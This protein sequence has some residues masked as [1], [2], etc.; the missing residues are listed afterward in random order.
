[1][2]TTAV[3]CA[4]LVRNLGAEFVHD[5]WNCYVTTLPFG[6]TLLLVWS[7]ACGWRWG[8]PLGMAAA[9]FVA[10]VHVG[11]VLL[12]LPAVAAG[13]V[14]LCVRSW[15]TRRRRGR[16]IRRGARPP[17][18]TGGAGPRHARCP[19]GPVGATGPGRARARPEQP[20][21][22]RG[23]VPSQRGRR[24]HAHPGPADHRWAVQPRRR[25]ARRQGS[26]VPGWRV[27]I[28]LRHAVAVVAGCQSR[29]PGSP[30]GGGQGQA[31]GSSS[32]WPGRSPSA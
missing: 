31:G 2:V 19:R 9:S 6:L 13:A 30:C 18:G 28:P 11:F 8:L 22:R 3:G 26:V 20:R 16:P 5:P 15:R 27:T 17:L 1:M 25:V 29:W 12:A 14:A 32:R 21:Q 24:A 4:L 23:L 10:Q 7:M